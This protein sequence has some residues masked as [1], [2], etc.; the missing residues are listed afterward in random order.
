MCDAQHFAVSLL[1]A[2]LTCLYSLHLVFSHDIFFLAV[3][4]TIYQKLNYSNIAVTLLLFSDRYM[5]R[6]VFGSSSGSIL[7]Y[8]TPY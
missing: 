2:L 5:F 3:K 7:K 8:A 6:S 1:A 4:A